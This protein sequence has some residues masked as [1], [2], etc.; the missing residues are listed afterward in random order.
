MVKRIL[1]CILLKKCIIIL[2]GFYYSIWSKC[3]I[4]VVE[5]IEIVYL[6]RDFYR[7]G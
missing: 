7:V 2:E 5:E 6:R 3:G 1:D 4:N